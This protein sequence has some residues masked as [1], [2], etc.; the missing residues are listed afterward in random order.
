M[1]TQI[2]KCD[3]RAK[4]LKRELLLQQLH[5]RKLTL[6]KMKELCGVNNHYSTSM[7]VDLI[8][9]DHSAAVTA[10][11]LTDNQIY[12]LL[13][14][15]GI[16]SD[17]NSLYLKL[18]QEVKVQFKY[19]S[20]M[21]LDKIR[22]ECS[23][24]SRAGAELT[25]AKRKS[26]KYYTPKNHAEYY[27]SNGAT[28]DEANQLA[29]NYRKLKSPFSKYFIKYV[30]LDD[31]MCVDLISELARNR[32]LKG[33]L[34]MRAGV[35]KLE[36][37]IFNDLL[38]NG[39]DVKRQFLLGKYSYDL[40]VK[41]YNTI[42]EINGTYWHADPRV[43]KGEQVIKFPYGELLCSEKWRSDDIKNNYARSQG[44]RVIVLWELDCREASYIDKLKREILKD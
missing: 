25:I 29:L 1:G 26:Q 44:Y 22:A 42:I 39:F 37:R 32:G 5:E 2:R 27:I 41:S 28:E 21:S 33:L 24:I 38:S 34:S 23:K 30:G 36:E 16:K 35:S 18:P 14:R 19:P 3:S 31:S 4:T 17:D 6:T 8:K 40:Y 9:R 11:G 13:H 15:L 20:E 7:I 12:R 43:F 10:S